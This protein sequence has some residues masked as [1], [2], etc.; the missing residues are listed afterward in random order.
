[1]S[2]SFYANK[3]VKEEIYGN[4]GYCY[5][6]LYGPMSLHEMLAEQDE[7]VLSL[8]PEYKMNLIAPAAMNDEDFA[9]FNSSL[10]EVLGF[11]KYSE[12]IEKLENLV[13]SDSE[14]GA[15]GRQEVDVLNACVNA[16]L[17]MD[18]KEEN[19]DMCLALQ[20]LA[21]RAEEK[22]RTEGRTEGVSSV[23]ANLMKNAS[24][25]FEK[26][27]ELLGIPDDEADFYREAITTK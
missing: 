8:V 22:G 12:D 4:K 24:V 19:V 27:M 25:S 11:I 13:N 21:Q 17:N 9:K 2:I 20:T 3:I 23:L 1:M 18:E 6:S 10:K 7:Q 26:A 14:F 5:G 16:D 15:L